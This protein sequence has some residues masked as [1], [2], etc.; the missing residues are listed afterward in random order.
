MG[1]LVSRFHLL[2]MTIVALIALL[3]CATGTS[4]QEEFVGDDYKIEHHVFAPQDI[5]NAST[6]WTSERLRD[7]VPMQPPE[8]EEVEESLDE[9]ANEPQDT[10]SPYRAR[11]NLDPYR[12]GGL[13]SFRVDDDVGDDEVS[14]CSAQFVGHSNVLLTSAHC[15]LNEDGDWVDNVTFI[16]QYDHGAG[17][18]KRVS[19]MAI[20]RGWRNH[21]SAVF[22]YA[23]LRTVEPSENG[24]LR[25]PRPGYPT[26]VVAMGY[27]VSIESGERMYAYGK[28]V[29]NM[30]RDAN[31]PLEIVNKFGNGKGS[32][33]GAWTMGNK[34]VV[35][36]SSRG[37]GKNMISPDLTH[38]QS[39]RL[40]QF[41]KKNCN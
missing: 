30:S 18:R 4:D 7:L 33:G 40:F 34:Y 28:S 10:S 25:R 16:Q 39:E 41:A 5:Q 6:Y 19:C 36:V 24:A 13:L 38:Q 11:L 37:K 26:R 20:Y 29:L 14:W 21:E 17:V 31:R 12:R 1:S 35:G 9:T 27:P 8:A 32:S 2:V 22:D 3:S 23:Y 15:V